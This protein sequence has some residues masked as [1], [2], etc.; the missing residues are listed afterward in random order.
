MK[1]LGVGPKPVSQR[2]VDTTD[3]SDT[4]D[5]SIPRIAPPALSSSE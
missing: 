2:K 5:A 3:T 4:F 1:K